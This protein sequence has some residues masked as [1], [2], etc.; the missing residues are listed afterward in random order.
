[1]SNASYAVFLTGMF[2]EVC[3][4]G[5]ILLGK[6]WRQYPYFSAYV[7]FFVTQ[8]WLLY[9]FLRWHSVLYAPWYYGS[10]RVNLVLRFLLVGEVFR[11][12]FPAGTALRRMVAGGFAPN[13]ASATE[14]AEAQALALETWSD[15]WGQTLSTVR[16][17]MNP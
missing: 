6:L 17:V 14:A 15:G 5:R 8:S 11:Q 12:T 7:I 16:K 10:G 3:L 1:M 9:A 2:L 13:P 4:L